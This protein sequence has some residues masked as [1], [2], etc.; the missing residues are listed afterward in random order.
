M[1]M[2]Y[3]VRVAE[4][5]LPSLAMKVWVCCKLNKAEEL[6]KLA[7]ALIMLGVRGHS[8]PLRHGSFECETLASS[9]CSS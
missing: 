7:S 6:S 9:T 5:E 2:N 4:I 8:N 3:V 1:T